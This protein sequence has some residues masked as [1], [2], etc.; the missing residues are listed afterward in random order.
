MESGPVRMRPILMTVL[1]TIFGLIPLAL[2][3]GEVSEIQAPMAT[4]VIGELLVLTLL[5]L[6]IVPCVY[7]VCGMSIHMRLSTFIDCSNIVHRTVKF[8]DYNKNVLPACVLDN[9]GGIQYENIPCSPGKNRSASFRGQL[10]DFDPLFALCYLFGGLSMALL[11]Q[12]ALTFG[13]KMGI[14]KI[15]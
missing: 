9:G 14:R 4:M 1:A 5:T 10:S 6:N 12:T 8:R 13:D 3:L 15:F 2:G 7:T 11:F